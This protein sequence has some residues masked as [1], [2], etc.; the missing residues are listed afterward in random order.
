MLN[1]KRRTLN[2]RGVLVDG[3]W[4]DNPI[5]V[6]DEFL[7]ILARDSLSN[8]RYLSMKLKRQC[9][10]DK[11]SGPDGFT[12]GF[13][14]RYWDL[15]HGEVTN[16]VRY[17]FTHCDIPHGCNSSFITLIP[18]NQNA[19]LVKDFRPISLIGSFYK[20]I[21]KIL[22]NRLVSVIKGLINEVQSAFIAE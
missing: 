10:T 20:I 4:I 7:I 11:A 15:I 13:Y 5:D 9:G 1:K 17:F 12:F 19:K 22:A 14:R 21:A 18:K 6:K 16:A 3:C 8:E 2:V